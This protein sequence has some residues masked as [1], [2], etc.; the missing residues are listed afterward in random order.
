M[1]DGRNIGERGAWT[2]EGDSGQTPVVTVFTRSMAGRAF[3][4]SR[5]PK[6]EQIPLQVSGAAGSGWLI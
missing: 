4:S 1:W 6:H 3:G 2:G 5:N